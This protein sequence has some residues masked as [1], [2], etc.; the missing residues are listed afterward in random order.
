M[1]KTSPAMKDLIIRFLKKDVSTN[2]IETLQAW[3]A[4][5]ATHRRYFIQIQEKYQR[6][7]IRERFTRAH[8]AQAWQQVAESI[9]V[10]HP[11]QKPRPDVH[12]N[13]RWRVAGRMAATIIPLALLIYFAANLLTNVTNAPHQAQV[14]HTT[15]ATRICLYLPDSS[16]VWLNAHSTLRYDANDFQSSTR[17]VH[18]TGEAFFQVTHRPA[19]F[20]VQTNNIDIHVKGT[21]F[22]VRAYIHEAAS[23]TTLREGQV[24]LQVKGHTQVYAM[25]PGQQLTFHTQQ[26]QVT[27]QAVDPADFT[28]WKEAQL[29]FDNVP[30]ANMIDKLENRY[31]IHVAID[32]ILAKRERI[33]I[34]IRDETI[35]EVLE[36]IQLSC[37]LKSIRTQDHIVLYE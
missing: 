37:Q 22:N 36:L 29:V 32:P 27:I 12:R 25:T 2:E 11:S 24:T 19:P 34:T 30:L 28:A 9:K 17:L 13:V 15:D 3:L 26:K 7:K 1:K 8:V 6:A 35:D 16:T 14:T 5:N 18:L 4:E 23:K 10:T 31:N 33:S 21:A 20:V